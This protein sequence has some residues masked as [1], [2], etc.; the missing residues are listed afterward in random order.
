MTM[1]SKVEYR[2][3]DKIKMIS[4]RVISAD[5]DDLNE[6][7]QLDLNTL[8]KPEPASRQ[9][10]NEL[11]PVSPSMKPKP[12]TAPKPQRRT[13][14]SKAVSTNDPLRD[15]SV[16]EAEE[17]KGPVKTE[18]QTTSS[19]KEGKI[20]IFLRTRICQLVSL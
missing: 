10:K 7:Q 4:T 19:Y 14:K 3:K 16:K 18:S 8:V 5:E 11:K 9:T 6:Y 12:T 20:Y 17:T 1:H 15:V 13:T 2:N